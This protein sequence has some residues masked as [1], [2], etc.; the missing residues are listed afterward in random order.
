MIAGRK[1]FRYSLSDPDGIDQVVAKAQYLSIAMA[2]GNSDFAVY[3]FSM[4]GALYA[5]GQW[6]SMVG[7]WFQNR[8]KPAKQKGVMS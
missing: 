4:S 1:W 6:R 7:I 8:H 2:V 3:K 5:L